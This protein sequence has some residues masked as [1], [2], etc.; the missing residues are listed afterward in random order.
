MEFW[1]AGILL[2]LCI[3]GIVGITMHMRK[4]NKKG[5]SAVGIA[6][7]ALCGLAL[8][9]YLILSGIMVSGIR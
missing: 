3:T 2:I 9:A 1:L 8:F 6:L 4:K 5:L 7:L